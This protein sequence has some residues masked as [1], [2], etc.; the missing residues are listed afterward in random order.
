MGAW[1]RP[2]RPF[3]SKRIHPRPWGVG[4]M[5]P[6]VFRPWGWGI[7]IMLLPLAVIILIAVLGFLMRIPFFF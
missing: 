4:P 2:Y 3:G 6:R 1:R 7:A 5:Q